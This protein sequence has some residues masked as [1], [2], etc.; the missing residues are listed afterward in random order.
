MNMKKLFPLLIIL[1]ILSI[2]AVVFISMAKNDQPIAIIKG[3]M[4]MEA[5]PFKVNFTNDPYCKMLITTQRNALQ[6]VSPDG[7]TWFFDDP[8]C[9]ILWIEDK[10]FKE[11]AKIWIYT[12]DTQKWIDAK[13]AWYG[14]K[15]DTAMGYGF[16]GREEQTEDTIDFKEMQLRM[17]RG[18]NLANPKIRK[19]LL[20]E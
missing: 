8:G 11:S 5:L 7:N 4:K 6:V 10:T 9:M 17:L 20:G 12:I 16:A 19:K 15:D 3:N 1:V 14:T 18:E 13:T 2:V